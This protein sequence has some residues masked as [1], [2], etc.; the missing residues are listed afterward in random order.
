M[1]F[2]V[3]LIAIN[4]MNVHSVQFLGLCAETSWAL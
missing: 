4:E 2:L 3:D 1:A